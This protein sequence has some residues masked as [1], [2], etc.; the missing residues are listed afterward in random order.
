VIVA[1]ALAYGASNIATKLISDGI[2]TGAWIGVAIWI[3]AAGRHRRDRADDR[4]DRPPTPPGDLRRPV[5]F[6]IQ[7]FLPIAFE[8]IYT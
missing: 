5:S 8:P 7:T 1:S 2:D 6:A 3:A 4:N